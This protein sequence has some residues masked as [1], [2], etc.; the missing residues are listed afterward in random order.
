MEGS[1][2]SSFFTAQKDLFASG[3]V[4]EIGVNAYAVWGAIKFYANHTTGEAWPGLREIGSKIGVSQQ[5][6]MRAVEVL[7]KAHLL[8]IVDKAQFKKKGPTYIARE[9]LTVRIGD[10]VLCTLVI[11]YV[12]AKL[13]DKVTQLKKAL[14]KGE[15][16]PGLWTEVEII[17]G[18]GFEWNEQSKTLKALLSTE[19]IQASQETETDEFLGNVALNFSK[20]MLAKK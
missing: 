14:E 16:S 8:R 1:I 11:D 12:P 4:A 3:L 15:H 9:R 17:P 5:T 20:K 13:K 6:A 2:D 18:A 7:Q 19:Y 10:L